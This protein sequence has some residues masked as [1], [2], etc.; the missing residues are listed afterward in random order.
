HA[1]RFL[2]EASSMLAE[3]LEFEDRL[4]KVARLSIP[5]IGDWCTI[6]VV[7]EDG[8]VKR[9]AVAALDPAKEQLERELQQRYPPNLDIPHGA[10]QVLRTRQPEVYPHIPDEM[11]VASARDED[12][13]AMLRATG[14]KSLMSLPLEARGRILGAIT[15]ATSQSDRS[16]QS[17]DLLLA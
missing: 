4:T 14:L 17:S 16:Y 13:L 10:P 9:V 6:D 8:T 12:H 15:F 3:S 1:L 2:A 11:L 7:E 5:V